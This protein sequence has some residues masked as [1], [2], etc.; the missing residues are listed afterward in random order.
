M[1]IT[2][3][4]IRN[5]VF[6]TMVMVAL[7]VLGV[8]S[9]MRLGVE[10]MPDIA[11]PGA[12]VEVSYPGASPEAVEREITKPLEESVNGIAGVKR[13]T[14]RSFEGRSQT[15]IEFTLDTDMGRAMQDVRDRVAAA[16]ARFPDDA[17]PPLINRFDNENSQP[18]VALALLS[19]TRSQRELSIIADQVVSRRLQR[20]DGVARVDVSGLA[21]REVRIDLD[22]ERLRAYA[23]TPAEV[24]KALDEANADE[25]VGL[26][27]NERA[28][29][30]LRV[31]GRV[32]DPREFE[33][34]IVAHRNG[35]PL[36]LGDLGRLVER[37]REPDSFARLN[38]RTAI[39]FNVFKQQDANIVATGEKVKEAMDELGR[40]LPP[41]T[42]IELVYAASDWVK[43]SLVG[44]RHTLIEGALLT[45]AIVFLF[46]HSWR[47]TVITGLT[48]PIAVISSFIAVHAFGFTLNFMT[49]M[50]LSLCIGLLIDDA[51]VVR[52]NIVRHV[53]MG[54][55]HYTAADEG[56]REIGLAVMAT[57][58]AICAVFVPVAFMGGIIGKFFYPFGITVVVAVLVSLFVSFTL[59]P[60]LSSVWRDPPS[61]RLARLPVI[62]AMLRGV[63]RGMDG[64][65]TVYERLIRW[66]FGPKRWR[67]FGVPAFARPFGADG[68]RDR[69]Q[70]RRW[71]WATL[72]PRGVVMATGG[73]SFVAALML[74]PLVGSEFVPQTDQGFTQLSIRMP[75]G[76]SLER[77]DAKV[78][79]VEEIVASFPEVKNVATSVGGQG[80]GLS[81]GRNQ[82]VLNIGLV[83]RR[84]RDRTQKQVEDAIRERI[85]AIPGI[86]TSVGFDRPIYVAILG[87]DPEGLAR[88]ASDFAEKVKKIPGIADVELSVKPGVPAYAVR[89][90]PAAVR[91][92]GLTAPQLASSLR[93][94]VNGEVATYW[95][96]P[97]GEQVEVLLR[98]PQDARQE[99]EQMRKLPVAFAKDGT[100]IPLDAVASI[101]SVVNP[102]V[103]RR[104]NLQRREAIF[105]GVQG[106]PAGDVGADV[107][108]LIAETSLPPGFTFDVGGQTKDQNEAFTAMLGAMALAVIFIYIVLASQ[109]G[110][111]VQPV[112]IMASLP[113]SLIGVMI[114]L[115]VSGSTLNVFSM[116]GLV[117]LMGLVTK[118]AI[119]LVDF[120]NHARR[121]G[122]SVPE[123]L[124]QAGLTRMRP[125]VMTTAAMVF[126]ML[127]L[128][129][130]LNDG[131]EI[132]APM[133]RA[134]IGGVITSTLL[135]LVVVPVLYSYLVRDRKPKPAPAAEPGGGVLP[136]GASADRD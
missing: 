123:A 44:L 52:E 98:L 85:A 36:R 131:G 39:N 116:I 40:T 20:V 33:N 72:T 61:A 134:I 15:S 74:A 67:L 66:A 29:A 110:S 103:I 41:D 68:R 25:P 27:S 26:L 34:T 92:L 118:N 65:H 90:L 113:L 79:Q 62:G 46:L 121:D 115:L 73:A 53:H 16:Q 101:E 100:P 69:S 4:S 105:A 3:V 50:A 77:S 76:S 112:A 51:I 83:D 14:S 135:T 120:A 24:A 9:Y 64:L 106:R 94:Y 7:C 104:Q 71:R 43:G 109:F 125:I 84:E 75:V 21:L 37:E 54:K 47:S 80:A 12:Y 48:L 108:K 93:A 30:I 2:R 1:W 17:K 136:A 102:E 126:G 32:R 42:Q 86:E 87:S 35:L 5:P 96:T 23:V 28:D 97:D 129:M 13:L 133:G 114:A 57:T 111:F 81:T 99:L 55:D 107:Q 49:M 6:A 122:A 19:D 132:Q 58:F 22:P 127:P 10:Q 119:L 128:A 91:E 59:D 60:M 95:T 11:L 89:L 70:R 88:V 18:V 78:R 124:L 56:T 63:D 38:G 130:A 117:M 82:A 31:E 8:F 45:V